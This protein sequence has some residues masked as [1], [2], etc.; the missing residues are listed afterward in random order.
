[1]RLPDARVNQALKGGKVVAKVGK[2]PIILVCLARCLT[3]ARVDTDLEAI[4]TYQLPLS[5][6]E[7]LP[8]ADR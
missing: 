7:F 5:F 4:Q 1:M 6:I 2:C 8:S 3:L